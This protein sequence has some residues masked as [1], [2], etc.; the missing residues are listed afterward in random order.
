MV[1]SLSAVMTKFYLRVNK[2]PAYSKIPSIQNNIVN[3]L[4]LF[5]LFLIFPIITSCNEVD[6]NNTQSYNYHEYYTINNFM[7]THHFNNGKG[8]EFK[9]ERTNNLL[10]ILDGFSF[11]STLDSA[12]V[13]LLL[14]LYPRFT[15]FI[16]E[17][18]Y[19]TSGVSY[20]NDPEERERYTI[21]NLLDNYEDIIFEY[22]SVNNFDSIVMVG[23]SEGAFIMPIL[24]SRLNNPNIT[25]LI[26]I[27][28]GGLSAHEYYQII[29]AD[30]ELLSSLDLFV[31]ISIKLTYIRI[32]KLYKT[33]PYPDSIKRLNNNPRTITYK[34]LNSLIHIRPFDYYE[35]ID[36]PVL[37]LHGKLDTN[38]HVESTR[39]VEKN[40]P[41]KPFSYI[42]YPDTAHYINHIEGLGHSNDLERTVINDIRDWFTLNGL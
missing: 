18:F 27:A 41:L 6:S 33:E 39:Y 32:N 2:I 30:K 3:L 28:G 20:L 13:P 5:L 7:K 31:R 40:L 16:P 14:K 22:L 23:I 35:N 11:G 42:Y 24:Y 21:N 15:I 12:S 29:A 9:T 34:Y 19:R 17:K 4:S 25:N 36:I 10:I 38:V 8:Y 37:F 1:S 26:S